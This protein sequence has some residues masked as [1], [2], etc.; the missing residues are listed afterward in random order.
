MSRRPLKRLLSIVACAAVCFLLVCKSTVAAEMPLQARL[1]SEAIASRAETVARATGTTGYCYAAVCKALRPLGVGLHGA[2]A[3]EARDL[4]LKDQR[5]VPLAVNHVDQLS[6][7]D[8]IV[9]TKSASHPYGHISVYQG[10]YEEASDHVSAVTHTQAY[11][12]AT[13][14]RLRN[15]IAQGY[16]PPVA[17]A[18][19]ASSPTNTG[20]G[21]QQATEKSKIRPA[22]Q[23]LRT[24]YYQATG[25]SLEGAL[26]RRAVGF[27]WAR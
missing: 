24:R 3:Y 10:N 1:S 4:L 23:K 21:K 2:A 25:R 6:R 17:W 12:G 14:F 13:V 22:W 20:A 27:L 19:R 15:E 9:Y 26:L 7:G 8:I 18:M 5:F 16:E 11:G